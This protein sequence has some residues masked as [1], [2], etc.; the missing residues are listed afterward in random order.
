MYADKKTMVALAEQALNT[1][2]SDNPAWCIEW[3]ERLW[4]QE[5]RMAICDAKRHNS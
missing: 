4:L 1:K 3:L 5:I 2:A